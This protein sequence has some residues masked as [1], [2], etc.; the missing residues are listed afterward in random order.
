MKARSQCFCTT[1]E[2]IALENVC[3][4]N[5]AAVRKYVSHI[6]SHRGKEGQEGAGKKHKSVPA[7]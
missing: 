1:V 5:Q 3:S 7:R 4:A 2:D 6:F